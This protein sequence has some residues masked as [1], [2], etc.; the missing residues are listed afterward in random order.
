MVER[1]RAYRRILAEIVLV[2]RV[3]AVPRD[4][5]QRR[6]VERCD[7][8]GTAPL[9]EELSGAVFILIS[10]DGGQEVALIGEAI[11]ADRPALGE[12]EGAAV[13]LA[14]ISTGNAAN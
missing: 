1:N 8:H 2:R 3:V 13:I 4:N 5:I 12:R 9:D 6:M 7:P 14:E 10:R 11:G